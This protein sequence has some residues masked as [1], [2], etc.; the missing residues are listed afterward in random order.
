MTY[1]D[2]NETDTATPR[3]PAFVA[4]A[5]RTDRNGKYEQ[6]GVAFEN[7]DGSLFIK[8]AGTQIVTTFV[9]YRLEA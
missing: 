2:N 6:I 1:D 4:K 8:L 7:D 9:L 3:K 5:K